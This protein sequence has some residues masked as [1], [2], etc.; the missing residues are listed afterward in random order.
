MLRILAK[1]LI[2]LAMAGLVGW[3]MVLLV[4][5][6]VISSNLGAGDGDH[7]E[8][9]TNI[10]AE[11]GEMTGRGGHEGQADLARGLAGLG[12]Q[13]AKVGAIILAVVLFQQGMTWLRRGLRR[14]QKKPV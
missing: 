6:G 7:G 11:R 5:K 9:Q 8:R 2:I 3:S 12:G 1:T 4:D 14:A 13:A 10:R